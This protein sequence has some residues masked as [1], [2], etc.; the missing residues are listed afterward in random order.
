MGVSVF[1]TGWWLGWDFSGKSFDF[2]FLN[3][4]VEEAAGVD[5]NIASLGGVAKS[6]GQVIQQGFGKA[7]ERQK[8]AALGTLNEITGSLVSGVKEQTASAI[9]SFDKV[10]GLGLIGD[11]GLESSLVL[12]I[13]A[14][15]NEP[16][17]FLI[18]SHSSSTNSYL[19]D[20]GDGQ[21][22][23]GFLGA[24]EEAIVKHTWGSVGDYII[25]FNSN[26]L[27]VRVIN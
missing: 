24:K 25:T 12:V 11:S 6:G 3:Q 10:I 9:K 2:N 13:A 19:I 15:A 4:A 8:I 26:Q 23:K 20:W 18:Q 1:A 21:E 16:V 27:L 22:S 14:R 5:I 17:S 7:V